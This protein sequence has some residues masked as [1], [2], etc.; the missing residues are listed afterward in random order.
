[1]SLA[2]SVCVDLVVLSCGRLDM[3]PR[4]PIGVPIRPTCCPRVDVVRL[5][6]HSTVTL[7]RSVSD[8][9]C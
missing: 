4:D 5:G 7:G 2:L 9:G 1:M 6:S 8:T 3:V